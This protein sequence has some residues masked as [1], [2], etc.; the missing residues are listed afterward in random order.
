MQVQVADAGSSNG[1]EEDG[2]AASDNFC[3]IARRW[4]PLATLPVVLASVP[5]PAR[6]T[7]QFPVQ[8]GVLRL[9]AWV[10]SCAHAH[11][12]ACH[13]QHISK[14]VNIPANWQQSSKAVIHPPTGSRAAKP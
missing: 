14:A 9:V 7:I 8:S 3:H 10:S 12:H 13:Q 2:S 6:A 11:M 5:A 1:E 4:S